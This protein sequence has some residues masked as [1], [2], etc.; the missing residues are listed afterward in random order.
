MQFAEWTPDLAVALAD[1]FPD[2]WVK[3]KVQGGSRIRFV[4]WFRYAERLNELVGPEGWSTSLSLHEVGGKLVVVASLTVLGVTKQN[5]GDEDEDKDN[6]GTACTN[7]FAQAY[8]RAA[9]LFG[10][11][12]YMYDKD[13]P[14]G[15][16]RPSRAPARRPANGT[17]PVPL[18]T[19]VERMMD[20][21][22]SYD[23][24]ADEMKVC[25]IAAGLLENQR[26]PDAHLSE[27]VEKLATILDTAKQRQPQ[28]AGV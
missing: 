19:Q 1:P 10:L 4:P 11:G 9:A 27:A 5:V 17:A 13:A 21:L 22:A 28:L 6:F 12:L 18:R 16:Q 2:A 3:E 15:Q 23:L 14:R 8:K 25:G 26:T 7:A 20:A 24:N